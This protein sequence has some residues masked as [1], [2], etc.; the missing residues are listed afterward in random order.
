MDKGEVKP[1]QKNGKDHVF[2]ITAHAGKH[3][4]GKAKLKYAV[5]EFLEK[6]KYNHY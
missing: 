1:N 3:S 4:V 2:K 5:K 6:Q